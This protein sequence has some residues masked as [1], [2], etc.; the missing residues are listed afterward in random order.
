M[1]AITGQIQALAKEADHV[2]RNQILNS[3][4]DLQYSLESPMDLFMRLY[5]SHLQLAI[6]YVGIDT[7]IFGQLASGGNCSFTAVELAEK[8][9]ASSDLLGQE[10][11]PQVRRQPAIYSSNH[12]ERILRYLA[13]IG[14]ITNPAQNQYGA[15]KITHILASPIAKA[16]IIHAF[17]TCG[18]AIQAVP[19][20]LADHKYQDITSNSETP[21]QKGHNTSLS[22]FKY[23]QGQPKLFNGLQQVM[24]AFQ[25]SAW[26]EGLGVLDREAQKLSLSQHRAAGED[27]PP[28]FVDIGGGH[29]HQSLH[30]LERYP[31]LSNRI[32]LQ[33]LPETISHLPS[34]FRSSIRATAQSF[35]EPQPADMRG[36]KFFYLRRILHD[37]PDEDCLKILAHLKDAMADG[38]GESRILID[39][40]VL[41][42]MGAPWQAF[43]QDLSMGI[44][45]GGKERTRA[46]WEALV[47]KAGLSIAEVKI[48]S[49]TSCAGVIV[50]ERT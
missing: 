35:F 10:T 5:N 34:T 42:D 49:P 22:T 45:F 44:L 16:G 8:L 36:A 47:G 37:W 21:F 14:Y 11:P 7:N 38:R 25:S 20:F 41:P 2:G 27:E 15:N 40:V 13:S 24:T 12:I 9:G 33:D 39:E 23:L 50:V 29:G 18:P 43:M 32:I 26:L 1:E 30:I 4:R 48:Y 17:D 3:L 28:F 19:S 46:E 6:T 31:H